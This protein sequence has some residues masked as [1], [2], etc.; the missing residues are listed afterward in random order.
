VDKQALI[1]YCE[2]LLRQMRSPWVWFGI[3]AQ[4]L[5]FMRFFWQW[6]VSE[7]EKRSTIPIAFWYFSIAG[8]MCTF[9]YAAG[10]KDPAIMLGQMPACFF[11]I[12]N[13]MLIRSHSREL[14][15][16]TVFPLAGTNRP[17]A[18]GARLES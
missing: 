11:Y 3:G 13:L 6:L 18:E 8:A 15:Q 9:V 5:F 12:R 16:R 10:R 1:R 4:G 7:R 2:E 14:R 17:P